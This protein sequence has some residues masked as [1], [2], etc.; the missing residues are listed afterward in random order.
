MHAGRNYSPREVFIWTLR[1]TLLF[2]GIAAAPTVAWAVFGQT[3][4]QVPWQPVALVGTAV[5][6][7]TGF[8]NNAA[9]GRLWEA[10]QIWGSI[11][12]LSRTWAVQVLDLPTSPAEVKKGLVV[13]HLAWLTALRFQLREKRAWETMSSPENVAY[14]HFYVVPEWKSDVVTELKALL[15]L[16]EVD[17]VTA[18]KNRA[19]H[20]LAAQSKALRELVDKGEL[21]E[22]RFIELERAVAALYDCQGR[23]ER[24]KNFPYPRQFATLNTYFVWLL[25]CS[26]P[27]ALLPELHKLG[28][29]YVWATIPIASLV[30]WIFHMI[31]KIGESSENPFEGGPND[32]PISSMARTIEIDLRELLGE[33]PPPAL[34][35]TNNILS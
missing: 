34:T 30:A 17:A 26:M 7:V 33:A 32:V 6:F 28:P 24:I 35:P 13:R 9:Y 21:T 23:C 5:A 11:I 3:W 29:H 22:L 4:L 16:A 10:R 2:V 14:Q 19:T 31:D 12:N 25:V 8:K 27:F 1:E 18:K 15:P 20:L